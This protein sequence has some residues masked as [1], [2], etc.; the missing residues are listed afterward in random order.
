MAIEAL[1]PSRRQSRRHNLLF[2]REWRMRR[3]GLCLI[4]AAGLA[5]ATGLRS[6]PAGAA[7]EAGYTPP[8]TGQL[9]APFAL[10]RVNLREP[11]TAKPAAKPAHPIRVIP[12]FAVP[13]DSGTPS[14]A[15]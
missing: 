7:A 14:K 11:T 9:S 1:Y 12:I 4:A 2:A 8:A 5:G 15:G 10:R 13:Q 6:V 3:L